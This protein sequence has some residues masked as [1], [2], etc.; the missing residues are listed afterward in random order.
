MAGDSV[1]SERPTNA[2]TCSDCGQACEVPFTPTPGRPVYC[3]RC[4]PKHRD[5][6]AGGGA[7]GPPRGRGGRSGHSTYSAPKRYTRSD[8]PGYNGPPE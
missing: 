8:Y 5:S 7:R 2:I 4:F 3:G 6:R 1:Q